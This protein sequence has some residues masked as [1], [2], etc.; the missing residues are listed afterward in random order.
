MCLVCSGGEKR[1]C[2]NNSSGYRIICRRCENYSRKV[3]YEGESGKNPYSR[4]LEHQDGL[5]LE[6]EDNPL[7]K[8]CILEHREK[9]G[10]K[11]KPL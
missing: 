3:I 8:H 4:G 9:V 2:E 10:F 5:G 7:W 1:Q 11:M 6:R